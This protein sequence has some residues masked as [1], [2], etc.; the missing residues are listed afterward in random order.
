MNKLGLSLLL[1]IFC[2]TILG[3]FVLYDSSSYTAQLDLHDKY[4]FIKNQSIWIILGVI[5]ALFVSRLKEDLLYNISLPLLIAT[6]G[7]LVLVFFSRYWTRIKWFPQMDKSG[8]I[9]FPTIGALESYF[10]ALS[11]V[12]AVY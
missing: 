7:S 1:I 8:C 4:Y 10:V 5:A 12:M 6:F 3:L 9:D 2:L 11:G